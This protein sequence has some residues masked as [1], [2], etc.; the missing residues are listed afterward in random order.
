[1][2]EDEDG[3]EM[4]SENEETDDR[5]HVDEVEVPAEPIRAKVARILNMTDLVINR[6]SADGVEVGLE[7]VVL[8]SKGSNITDPDTG[9]VIGSVPVAKTIVKIVNVQEGLAIARTFR[10][11]AGTAGAAGLL[12]F[13][14]FA[15]TPARRETLKTDESR[16]A[17]ELDEA[18]SLVKIGDE[19]VEV[20]EGDEYLL[21]SF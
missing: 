7:F 10:Q 3:S 12:S 20:V 21:A 18:D 11:K 15:G 4:N 8:N 17:Q 16:A 6:G 9:D 19:V 14:A 1:M 5:D 13:A 2:A